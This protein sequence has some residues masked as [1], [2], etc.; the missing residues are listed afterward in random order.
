MTQEANILIYPLSVQVLNPGRRGRLCNVDLFRCSPLSLWLFSIV[1]GCVSAGVFLRRRFLLSSGLGLA[2]SAH[3]GE[4][5]GWICS[6]IQNVH[7]WGLPQPQPQHL[8]SQ[9]VGWRV[10]ESGLAESVLTPRKKIRK[11]SLFIRWRPP[12]FPIW[13]YLWMYF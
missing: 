8:W 13:F 3:C 4:G 10:W 6:S 1:R 11:W 7:F 5:H 12:C 2:S 9:V